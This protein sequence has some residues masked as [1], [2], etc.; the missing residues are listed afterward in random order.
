MK[1]PLL[2]LILTA[3]FSQLVWA[4]GLPC[5]SQA[6]GKNGKPLSGAAKSAF[7][8]KCEKNQTK[9]TPSCTEKAIS[10]NGKPLSGAAKSAFIKKCE[11]S[12][13]S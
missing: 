4:D 9:D 2:A 3:L 7:I 1:K 6:V 11:Q 10:K 12:T 8:K 13:K 5:E